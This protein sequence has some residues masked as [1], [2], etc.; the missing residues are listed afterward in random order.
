MKTLQ[1]M[2]S[3]VDIRELVLKTINQEAYKETLKET[4]LDC[5][6]KQII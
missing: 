3:E 4:I 5:V 1:Q 2:V 6:T